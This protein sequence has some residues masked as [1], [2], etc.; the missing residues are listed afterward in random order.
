MTKIPLCYVEIGLGHD[1]V[2][3]TDY[4][5]GGSIWN[6]WDTVTWRYLTFERPG[7]CELW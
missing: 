6:Q 3:V 1:Y 5:G 2:V 4:N 7:E